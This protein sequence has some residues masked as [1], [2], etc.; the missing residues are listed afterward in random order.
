MRSQQFN[1][2]SSQT[3]LGSALAVTSGYLPRESKLLNP[4]N[5]YEVAQSPVSLS[6]LEV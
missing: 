5:G 6:K 1:P 4:N 3:T 2:H